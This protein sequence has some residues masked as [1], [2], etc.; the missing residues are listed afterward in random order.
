MIGSWDVKRR[1]LS[2]AFQTY[3][4]I[5]PASDTY[6]RQLA[7]LYTRTSTIQLSMGERGWQVDDRNDRN[8]T[9]Q[10]FVP[11]QMFAHKPTA[12]NRYGCSAMNAA[13]RNTQDRACRTLVRSEVA[14]EFFAMMKIILLG[15]SEQDFRKSNG[16][17]A[18]AWETFAGR[19]NTL[20]ADEFGTLPQVHEVRGDSPDGFISTLNHQAQIMSGHTGLPPQYHGIFSDGNPA[21]ADAIRMSDFR[22]KTTAD[23]LAV[24]FGNDWES[25]MRMAR[26]IKGSAS[27]DDRQMETD[28]AYTGI[29]TPNADAVTIATQVQAGLL[30]PTSDDALAF[31][32]WTAVQR[33]RIAAQRDKFQ[34]QML[35]QQIAGLK[36]PTAPGGGNPAQPMDGQQPQALA[37][38]N[39]SRSTDGATAG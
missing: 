35:D 33:K 16:E 19:L 13:W 12:R 32:G 28:W 11:V 6:L 22:L 15:V 25:V 8:V 21:S 2:A 3:L 27:E 17:I 5:D 31:L 37:G 30:P 1:E 10:Q 14:G 20:K 23:R 26:R 7:T 39:T 36:P 34:L 29:P 4:D 24:S 18:T 9:D 38:L